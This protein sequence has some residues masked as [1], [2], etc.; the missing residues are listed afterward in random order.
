MP[1]PDPDTGAQLADLTAQVAALAARAEAAEYCGLDLDMGST[2]PLPA[3]PS[4]IFEAESVGR[5]AVSPGL[6]TGV[7][8]V[9]L[10]P[11]ILFSSADT[12]PCCSIQAR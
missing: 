5:R 7:V 9:L 1:N 12:R 8:S 3:L 10:P 6:A 4:A 11:L 2:L